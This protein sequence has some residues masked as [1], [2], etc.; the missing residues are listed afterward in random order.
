MFLHSLHS[1]KDDW[2]SETYFEYKVSLALSWGRSLSYRNE[3][4][5]LQSKS[6]DWFLYDR[7]LRHEGVKE[8]VD[9]LNDEEVMENKS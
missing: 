4:I 8:V 6:V 9:N 7:D 2:S 3:F 1:F 5:Y